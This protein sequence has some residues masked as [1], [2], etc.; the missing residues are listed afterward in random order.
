[1]KKPN[2]YK[3]ILRLAYPISLGQLG[4]VFAKMADSL[5]LGNYDVEHLAASAFSF[6]VFITI[7]LLMGFSIGITPLVA[8]SAPAGA[9]LQRV[10]CE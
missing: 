7:L 9:R 3:S 6:N 2:Y 10:Q 5:M 4:N 1:M 8:Q